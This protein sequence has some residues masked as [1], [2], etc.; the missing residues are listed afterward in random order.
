MSHRVLVVD[1]E[2]LN[3]LTLSDILELHGWEVESAYGG[4]EAVDAVRRRDFDVV[5][6]DVRMPDTTGVEA[7][8]EM[9]AIR[10]DLKVVMMTGYTA[11]SILEEARAE[12]V[13]RILH[14][15]LDIEALVG[16]LDDLMARERPGPHGGR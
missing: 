3:V 6:M 10:G 7:L 13:I 2:V 16:L 15:P 9:R 8:K 4:I 1:D 5:V 11:W 14:K 12:G